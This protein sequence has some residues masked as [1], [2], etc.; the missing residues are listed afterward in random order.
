SATHIYENI[1]AL[2]SLYGASHYVAFTGT[3]FTQ[4]RSFFCF[5]N[6]LH[7]NLLCGLASDATEIT[8]VFQREDNFFIKLSIALNFSR[9][10]NHDVMLGVKE[11][12]F[13]FRITLKF[14]III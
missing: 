2:H 3:E 1:S 11:D 4:N 7:D 5:A 14:F 10:I 13:I 9:I 12:S 8:F 6:F